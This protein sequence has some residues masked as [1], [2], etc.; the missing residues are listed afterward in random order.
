[1]NYAETSM[2]GQAVARQPV[3]ARAR[4]IMRTYGHL[5][6]AI[7]AFTLTEVFLFS[8]GLAQ[9]IAETMLRGSW[10]LVLGAFMIVGVLANRF[11]QASHPRGVQYA[12]LGGYVVVE[13]IVFVPLLF[14]AN[15]Y[16]PGAIQ[17]AAMVTMAGFAGL[18]F[19]AFST[20]KDFSFLNGLLR[21]GGILALV[22]IGASLLFGFHLGTWFSVAMVGFAGAAILRDTSEVLHHYDEQGYVA[23]SLQLFSS[24]ALMFWYVLQLFIRARD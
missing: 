24:V 14:M 5:M 7:A 15:S 13:A 2:L 21:W 18:T 22:A 23:A 16:A 6:G 17:S 8:S 9:G 11:A 20:R 19:V 3:Q 10:M 12:A 1:M 4:F